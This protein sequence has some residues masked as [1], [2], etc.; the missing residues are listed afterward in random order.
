MI[1]QLTLYLG[2]YLVT[3]I[4]FP[5]NVSLWKILPML[6]IFSSYQ[7]EQMCIQ[8]SLITLQE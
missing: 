5:C 7:N 8:Y 1:S 2:Q 6:K 3:V 4:W